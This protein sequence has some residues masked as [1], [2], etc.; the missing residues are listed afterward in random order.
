MTG[1]FTYLI[2]TST[3]N[4]LA[5]TVRR[6]RS[7]RYAVG[8][9]LVLAYIWFGLLRSPH[10][11][12]PPN[13][14]FNRAFG[15]LLPVGLFLGVAWSWLFGADRTSLAFSQAE[16]TMLF[17][18][19]VSRRA[20]ILYKI[21]RMQG[22][23]LTTAVIWGVIFGRGQGPLGVAHAIGYW[24]ALSIF[25]L[26]RL[27]VALTRAS[28][29]G[30]GRRGMRRGMLA[31]AVFAAFA[32][33]IVGGTIAA[34][35]TLVA[36]AQQGRLIGAVSA[37]AT[38]APIRWAILPFQSVLAPSFATTLA[39]WIP[40]AAVALALMLAHVAWVLSG[41]A[42]FEETAAELSAERAAQL[43]TLRT[44]GVATVTAGSAGVGRSLPLSPVGPP[45]VALV[46]KNALWLMRTGQVRALVLLPLAL[47]VLAVT[48]RRWPL[49]EVLV[50]VTC[51]AFT[52]MMLLFGP[53]AMR[54]DLRN[55]LLHLV[56]LKTFPLSGRSIVLASV[57]SSAA[58]VAAMQLAIGYAGLF[59]YASM[60]GRKLHADL[61]A[62]IVVGAPLMIA[63]L[64]AVNFTI[65]NGM[66]LLFPAWVRL[67]GTGAPDIE[68]MGLTMLNTFI[69]FVVL[70]G[71]LI[72]PAVG[73]AIAYSMMPLA[74][75]AGI[76][77]AGIAAGLLLGAEAY[78]AIVLLGRSMERVE[79][80]EV[81]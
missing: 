10:R 71:F 19:P 9:L 77:S 68:A 7:P 16:V 37:L 65:H 67:G 44:R 28:H 1:A 29:G 31:T 6:L 51:G 64:N 57:A 43:E 50:M 76:A 3:R 2:A 11:D 32:V 47:W 35:G 12:A 73:A 14:D 26:H 39:A 49:G 45:A 62:G 75:G 13:L 69:T 66:A 18:A 17:T 54:N 4:R 23:A 80:M 34:R 79:P 25:A 81:G 42:A 58:V 20:L 72:V 15:L 5:G 48:L 27:G 8:L 41:D 63:G 53:S 59:A 74:P 30:R 55:E 46:W 61:L 70:I 52:L 60:D 24:M 22:P 40:A 56:M 33:V 78:G 38:S 21:A 36:A